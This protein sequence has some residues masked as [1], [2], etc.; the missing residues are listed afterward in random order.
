M[1]HRS[2][3]FLA[4]LCALLAVAAGAFGAHGL[5]GVLDEYRMGIYRTGVEYQMWHALGLGLVAVLAG[6]WP[7]ARLLPVAGWLMFVGI[8]L[9]SGSLYL[10][11]FTGARWLGMITPFGGTAFLGAWLLLAVTALRHR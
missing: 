6:Q 5:R 10:L 4:A 3:L 7:A 1:Y 2:F 8:V 11:A 9:F